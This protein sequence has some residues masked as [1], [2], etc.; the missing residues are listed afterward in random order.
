MGTE[1]K[2]TRRERTRTSNVGV[3]RSAVSVTLLTHTSNVHLSQ[4]GVSPTPDFIHRIYPAST[5]LRSGCQHIQAILALLTGQ[6][7][8]S[9][10]SSGSST[11]T[12]RVFPFL[13]CPTSYCAALSY[14]QTPNYM[15]TTQTAPEAL[16]AP[17]PSH[18]YPQIDPRC[19][20]PVAV[21]HLL[22]QHST[23]PT[24]RCSVLHLSTPL[25]PG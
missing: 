8:L 16:P 19:H 5:R 2:R 20:L 6:W 25:A 18:W 17:S 14:D 11:Q 10:H 1:R 9:A 22:P 7:P 4:T 12:A 21:W 23:I 24:P 3:G 13:R 15:F